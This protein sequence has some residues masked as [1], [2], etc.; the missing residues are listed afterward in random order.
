MNKKIICIIILAIVLIFVSACKPEE[1]QEIELTLN[2]YTLTMEIDEEKV[3]VATLINSDKEIIWLSS[4]EN[5]ATVNNGIVTALSEGYCQITARVDDNIYAICT[6]NVVEGIVGLYTLSLDVSGLTLATGTS[7]KL[8]PL[9]RK[10]AD[11]LDEIISFSSSDINTITVDDDG[12][13]TAEN[14]GEANII[15]SITLESKEINKTVPIKVI[16]FSEE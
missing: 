8:N 3:I 12:I 5:I 16:V 4:N 14:Q 6:V 13:I 11:V 10:G 1:I 7:Y 15:I 9:L 2:K